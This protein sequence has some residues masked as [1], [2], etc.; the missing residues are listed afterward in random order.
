MDGIGKLAE[1]GVNW[2]TL[3]GGGETRAAWLKNIE[4]L[5]KDI[6]EKTKSL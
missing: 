3:S 5:S 6:V 4:R 1:M 2:T